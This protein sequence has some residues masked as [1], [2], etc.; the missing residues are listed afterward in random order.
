[1]MQV[2]TAASHELPVAEDEEPHEMMSVASTEGSRCRIAKAYFVIRD[3][4]IRDD[5]CRPAERVTYFGVIFTTWFMESYAVA[6]LGVSFM[7]AFAAP[8]LNQ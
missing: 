6:H 2:P 5:R 8:L 3:G 4:A 1:M 7:R